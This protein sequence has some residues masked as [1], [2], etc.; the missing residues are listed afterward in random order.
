MI[1]TKP[2][3]CCT[4]SYVRERTPV[5]NRRICSCEWDTITTGIPIS[6]SVRSIASVVSASHALVGSSSSSTSGPPARATA[7]AARCASPPESAPHGRSRAA[8]SRDHAAQYRAGSPA[9]GPDR[10]AR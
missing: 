8:G 5:Q 9:A 3:S 1:S 10:R 4:P 7:S 6:T 2:F